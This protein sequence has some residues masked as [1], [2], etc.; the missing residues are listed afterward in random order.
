MSKERCGNGANASATMSQQ[1]VDLIFGWLPLLIF[2]TIVVVAYANLRGTAP[3]GVTGGKTYAC[4]SCGRRA[5][6]EHMVPVTHEGAVVWY[7]GRCAH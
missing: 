5:K 6:H 2:T 1:T 4:A 3:A 7:C